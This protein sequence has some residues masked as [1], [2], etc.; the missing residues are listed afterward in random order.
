M[1]DFRKHIHKINQIEDSPLE[2][3]SYGM[4]V[5]FLI[6]ITSSMETII[7][8]VKDSIGD[9]V[10]TI[11][12]QVDISDYRL[13]IILSDETI[14]GV[15]PNYIS[16]SGYTSLT[17]SQ[18]NVVNAS[19]TDKYTTALEMLSNNNE[20]SFTTQLD[21]L[22]TGD[23]PMGSGVEAAE[24]LEIGLQLLLT[25]FVNPLRGGSV[26]KYVLVFTD[27]PPGGDDGGSGIEAIMASITA[28]YISQGIKVFVFGGGSASTLWQ[29]IATNTGGSY[30][31]DYDGETIIEVIEQGCQNG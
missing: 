19:F 21:K 10:D 20:S 25:G 15:D 5:V 9:I 29:D 18:K 6:D 24:P 16:S 3:C 17:T 28:S 1:F 11:E 8:S 23:F 7:E 4:D 12:A 26:V 13:G 22:N 31:F 14:S 27:N 2:P 30:T